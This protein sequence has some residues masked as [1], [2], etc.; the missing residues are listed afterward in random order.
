MK[1]RACLILV[2]LFGCDYNSQ[3]NQ[4]NSKYPISIVYID[5]PTETELGKFPIKR[6]YY[7]RLIERLENFEV[8]YIIL[9]FFLVEKTENDSALIETLK[10]YDNILTQAAAVDE[11]GEDDFQL[12]YRYQITTNDYAFPNYTKALLPYSELAKNFAGIGFV[13]AI[14]EGNEFKE[15]NLFNS[16]NNKIYP[17]LPLLIIEK[18][19]GKKISIDKNE[20]KIGSINIPINSNGSFSI[21]LSE[22]NKLYRSYSFLDVLKDKIDG[23]YFKD[24]IVIV[25]LNGE[26]APMC[27]TGSDQPRNVAEILADAI[28]TALEYLN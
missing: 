7:A 5:A 10:K 20:V 14:F 15:F 23:K 16:L 3:E 2:F 21:N 24:N 25:F 8:K 4:M 19:L 18:E 17:S 12:L 26:K 6:N 13:N 27:K 1:L 28:N 9:K 11:E 22:P